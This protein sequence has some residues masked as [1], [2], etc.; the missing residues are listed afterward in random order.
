MRS[1]MVSCLCQDLEGTGTK[2]R[3]VLR[4]Q[5]HKF[6]RHE[7]AG[8]RRMCLIFITL[9]GPGGVEVRRRL[10]QLGTLSLMTVVTALVV[11]WS[12]RRHM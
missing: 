12:Q 5:P 6:R 2:P 10:V 7:V 1:N 11:M 8:I 9:S 4:E 3:P